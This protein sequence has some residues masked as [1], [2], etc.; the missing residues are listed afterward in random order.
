VDAF[1]TWQIPDAAAADRFVKTVRTP[2]QARKLLGPIINGRLAAVVSTMPIED[3]VGVTD[4]QGPLAAVAGGAALALPEAVFRSDDVR[5][6]DERTERV[7]R[8]LLGTEGVTGGPG[9]RATTS[10]PRRWPSTASR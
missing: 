1:V 7:R 6:I 3:L 9:A 10:A 4:T 2:E 8:K 5:L